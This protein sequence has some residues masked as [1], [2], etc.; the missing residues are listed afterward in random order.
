MS[1]NDFEQLRDM[2]C[3]DNEN[4]IAS[5]LQIRRGTH[6]RALES[7]IQS[8]VKILHDHCNVFSELPDDVDI[9]EYFN[10]LSIEE[11]VRCVKTMH[12]LD[13]YKFNLYSLKD[14]TLFKN[15]S[16]VSA[17]T[18]MGLE[19]FSQLGSLKNI[20][21]LSVWRNSIKEVDIA[22]TLVSLE[23]NCTNTH[24]IRRANVTESLRI[25][26]SEN[27]V[28]YTLSNINRDV[29][30][31]DY[32]DSGQDTH[33][34]NL[35]LSSCGGIYNGLSIIPVIQRT[36]GIGVNLVLNISNTPLSKDTSKLFNFFG[37]IQDTVLGLTKRSLIIHIGDTD[38]NNESALVGV[39]NKYK[40][41]IRL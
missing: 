7:L 29:T 25:T 1:Q 40:F 28:E 37:C 16:V 27:I 32:I 13:I 36:I 22:K 8:S 20:K 12:A 10:S 18:E 6:N 24:Y 5:V 26:N 3:E 38:L 31:K 39:S 19:N 34:L 33:Y 30:E 41:T 11:Q 17:K 21:H 23:L 35:I 2:L 14:L 4:S 15:L 9:F